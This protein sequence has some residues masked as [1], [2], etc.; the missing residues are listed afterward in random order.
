MAKIAT[1]DPTTKRTRKPKQPTAAGVLAKLGT[2]LQRLGAAERALLLR[3][4]PVYLE[5]AAA[6]SIAQASE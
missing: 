6:P 3:L 2:E 5:Q 4:L 1:N